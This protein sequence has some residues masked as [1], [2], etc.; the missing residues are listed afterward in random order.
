MRQKHKNS[1]IEKI[2]NIWRMNINVKNHYELGYTH[3]K[4]L[5]KASHPLYKLLN[6]TIVKTIIQILAIIKRKEL[7]KLRIQKKHIEEIKG[8]SHSTKIPYNVL[9]FINCAFDVYKRNIMCSSFNFFNE[10]ETIIGRNTD[11]IEPIA[12]L[13]L[14]KEGSIITN[15]KLNKS[16]YTHISLP[17]MAGV[18][19][20]YN[21]SGITTN[22][23]MLHGVKN[24]KIKT[25]TTPII[26]I[27]KQILE[28]AK[29]ITETKKIL[30]ASKTTRACTVLI[31]STKEKKS[32]L[33]ETHPEKSSFTNNTKHYQACTNHYKEN[34]MKILQTGTLSETKKRLEYLD[35]TL[36]KTKIM[37]IIKAKEILKNIKGG[38][39]RKK[40]GGKS[41]TNWV[42]FQ[43]FIFVPEKNIIYYSNGQTPPV[44]ITGE[45]KE[46]IIESN[47]APISIAP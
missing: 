25:K 32:C 44:S 30:E 4:L 18:L 3:G 22:P 31:T 20:G 29:T 15:V 13:L 40:S 8:L 7:N 28:E 16:E 17:M 35:N 37:T 12:K 19:S 36:D 43:S 1:Y 23:H 27:L 45:Y 41:I 47:K 39:K 26:F 2:N 33:Y 10:D 21:Q 6:N 9:F 34:E 11:I 42:T 14:K 24:G 5:K 46:I 38:A